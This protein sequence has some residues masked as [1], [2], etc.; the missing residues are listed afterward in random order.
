MISKISD[1][2][3]E[4]TRSVPLRTW[5]VA[6]S[7]E[8]KHLY[9]AGI[10]DPRINADYLAMHILGIWN[11][12]ELRQ[13][14][15]QS[16]T[17]DQESKFGELMKRRL[18]QEPL[19]H[20]IGETEFFGLRLFTS[21]AALIPRPETEILVEETLKETVASSKKNLRIL[22]IGT[23]SGAIALAIASRL[24]DASIIGIDISSDAVALAEKNK[25]RLKIEN[26]SFEM[27]DIFSEYTSPVDLIVSNPPY[28]SSEEFQTLEPEVKFYDPRIALTDEADGL[29]FYKRIAEIAPKILNEGGRIIVEVGYNAAKDVAKIFTGAGFDV[30]RIVKD[31]QGI[32]RVIILSVA[33]AFSRREPTESR[34]Y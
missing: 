14:L 19:Q 21:P 8:S 18:N 33:P 24:P 13:Y 20:I 2:L 23:G 11:K 12:S 16:L 32:E 27:S 15:V 1:K 17:T 3:K 26:V 7:D 30:V 25:K 34:L 31:L 9:E 28:I 4:G 29:S 10:S 5:D 6:I 22:D